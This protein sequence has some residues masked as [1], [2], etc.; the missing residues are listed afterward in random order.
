MIDFKEQRA[1][2]RAIASFAAV[3]ALCGLAFWLL[4]AVMAVK[5]V[6]QIETRGLNAIVEEIWCSTGKKCL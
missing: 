4:V 5:T 2:F 3:V 1:S 6:G